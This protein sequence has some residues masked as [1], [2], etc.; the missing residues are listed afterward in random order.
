MNMKKHFTILLVCSLMFT[1][2]A[3][4]KFTKI[5]KSTDM[6]AKYLA[7][8]QYYEKER[9]YQ[10][11]QLFEE[12]ITVFRGTVKA[13]DT[14]YYYCQCYY[15]TGEY[16][17]AAYHY[18]NF[19][20]TF[21][22]SSRAEEA[23]F[24]N[25]YCYYLDS[26]PVSLDQKNTIDAIRQFQLFINRYPKSEKVQNSNE[27][28]DEL[29]FKLETKDFNN[30]KL[31]FKTGSHKAAVV[32][33]QN[34]IKEYPSS[35]YKEECL[36]NTVRASFDYAEQSIPAKQVERYK[37]T[38]EHYYKLVDAFPS[39]KY[40]NEAEKYFLDAQSRIK[41]LENSAGII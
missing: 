19:N 2:T 34:V 9:Y 38:I 1:L 40:L 21:P 16:T 4:S 37:L 5:Q 22:N 25:A 12:L 13:E 15:E 7:A 33:F 8:V 28:I 23:L 32:A 18:N 3:C 10:A 31:Y 20:Q 14:Y 17:V 39:G 29:R 27:L 30:A 6:E 35:I 36:Y 24:K 41:K 26:P 11:L